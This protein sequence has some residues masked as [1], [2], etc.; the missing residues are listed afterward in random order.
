MKGPKTSHL[1]FADDLLL[2]CK[3]TKSQVEIVLQAIDLFTKASSLKN[4]G[5]YLG[6]N[7]GH[8]RAARRTVQEGQ[9][10]S[11]GLALVR[12]N[13]VVTPKSLEAL[14]SGNAS[15]VWV[16][17]VKAYGLLNSGFSWYS[18]NT[19]QFL[20]HDSW[21][22]LG[23]LECLLPFI[24]IS[25]LNF[26]L[27]DVIHNGACLALVGIGFQLPPKNTQ[28]EVNILATDASCFGCGHSIETTLRCLKDCSKAEA[29]WRFSDL[30]LL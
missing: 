7:I 5:R 18:G 21:N 2:F 17:I 27:T 15:H 1:M 11:R 19:Q 30:A 25:D 8:D 10:N 12:W 4:L 13:M 23:K 20:W 26:T 24:H 29:I 14:L 28:L 9:V 6:V 16:N 22:L 3:A